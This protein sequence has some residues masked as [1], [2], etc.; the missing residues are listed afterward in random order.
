VIPV[1]CT[2]MVDVTYCHPETVRTY[3]IGEN[4]VDVM[5]IYIYMEA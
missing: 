5:H 2:G 1:S 4:K 3:A